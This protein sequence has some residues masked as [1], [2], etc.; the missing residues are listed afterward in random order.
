MKENASSTSSSSTANKNIG[1]SKSVS[2]QVDGNI[3]DELSEKIPS[4]IF[5]LNELIKNAYDAFSPDISITI[6]LESDKLII[7]DHGKGMSL[8]TI[9]ELFHLSRS[10]KKFGQLIQSN[11]IKRYTQGSKGLGFLSVFKFGDKVT[12]TTNYEG[13]QYHFIARKS[14]IVGLTNITN[15]KVNVTIEPSSKIGTT[16]EIESKK[17]ELI[18]LVEYFSSN[19]N[20]LK[21]VGSF[22]DKEFTIVLNLPNKEQITSNSIPELST[23]AT[24]MQ[25]LYVK[26][27]SD[28]QVIYFYNK[29][30]I[31]DSCKFELSSDRYSINLEIVIYNLTTHGKKKISEIYLRSTDA[32]LT[33]LIFINNNLFNNYTLFD[34]NIFR[35]RKSSSALPQMIGNINIVSTEGGLEFNSDRTNFVEN[36]V[37]NLLSRDIRNLNEKIQ[38]TGSEIKK[39]VKAEHGETPTGQASPKNENENSEDLTRLASI[40]LSKKEHLYNIPSREI[41]L[42]DL[43]DEAKNSRGDDIPLEE[44]SVFINGKKKSNSLP[45]VDEPC[46]KIIKFIF[47]DKDK[48]EAKAECTLTFKSPSSSITGNNRSNELFYLISAKGYSLSLPLVK[49]IINQIRMAHRSTEDYRALI[50]ASL[51][52]I[53]ELSTDEVKVKHENIFPLKIPKG[54]SGGALNWQVQQLIVYISVNDKLATNISVKTG[55]EYQTL[56]N[57]LV[58]KDFSTAIGGAHLGAHKSLAYLSNDKI[59]DIA[60]YAGL[61]AMFADVILYK[62]D[63]NIFSSCRRLLESDF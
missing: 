50:A 55:I 57:I 39:R 62:T 28:E 10:S 51:R 61:V 43:I 29:G 52:A 4:N 20:A 32:A 3:I 12:W 19:T 54:T 11:G 13:S 24:T 31:V 8:E 1:T 2:I 26:Y 40:T 45:T 25:F 49:D 38:E 35:Q 36:E 34:S 14:E 58:V 9:N 60:K 56:K 18:A 46:I 44:I 48:R 59:H 21:L 17:N 30:T 37:S 5:A 15:H 27:H 16:I 41:D 23:I 7:S 33:P 42:Y 53:F 6:N 47:I 63:P 22:T